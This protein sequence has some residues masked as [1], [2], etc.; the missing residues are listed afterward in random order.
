MPPDARR[1]VGGLAVHAGPTDVLTRN[2]EML[3]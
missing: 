3:E 1:E 2:H